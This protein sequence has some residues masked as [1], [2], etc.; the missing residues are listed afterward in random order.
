MPVFTAI[1]YFTEHELKCKGTGVI[2]LDDRFAEAL[3][4]L[5][6]A[7]GKPL[8]PTSVCRTPEYNKA[9]GGHPR[10]LHLTENPVWPTKGTMAADIDWKEWATGKQQEF[11]ELARAM[12]W[13]VGLSNSFIHID[14]GHEVG[15]VIPGVY[16]YKGYT[17][18]VS[19]K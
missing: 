13:R 2:K 18:G 6:E 11:A 16:F 19:V 15:V 14:R 12:G 10:S 1:P 3:P 5:R 4:K 8:V 7:W 9:I 17:G